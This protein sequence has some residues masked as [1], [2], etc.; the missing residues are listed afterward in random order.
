[1]VIFKYV[2]V[3]MEFFNWEFVFY[4][5]LKKIIKQNKV[6]FEKKE[7]NILLV[8]FFLVYFFTN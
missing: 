3:K 2:Y 1:M 8:N 5:I 4:F 7:K 6:F